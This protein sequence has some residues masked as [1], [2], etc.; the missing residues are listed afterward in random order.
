MDIE[1]E[2]LFFLDIVQ[3]VF[4]DGGPYG[5]HLV[6]EKLNDLFR[7]T[8]AENESGPF[9]EFKYVAVSM[10]H[11]RRD[12]TVAK[13]NWLYQ[14]LGE[15]GKTTPYH[16][17]HISKENQRDYALETLPTLRFAVL[18]TFTPAL[19]RAFDVAY[20]VKAEHEAVVTVLALRRWEIEKGSYP[21]RLQELVD[22]GYL[23][24]SFKR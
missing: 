3:H 12:E 6:P 8:G 4:T 15:Q 11:A 10:L 22:G 17:S 1:G 20:R 23:V 16:R 2:R 18:K 9:V 13:C 7:M 21:E 5:G 24:R 14:Q 19:G